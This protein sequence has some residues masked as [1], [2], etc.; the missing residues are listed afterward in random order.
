M[1]QKR[2]GGIQGAIMSKLG[3]SNSSSKSSSSTEYLN[4]WESTSGMKVDAQ[5]MDGQGSVG[6]GSIGSKGSTTSGVKGS[7]TSG[8]KGSTT[9]GVSVSKLRQLQS[10]SSS[11]SST[12]GTD[13][14]S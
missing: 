8:V 5:S 12:T 2:K 4:L 13:I 6:T 10:S 14:A 3:H 11:S 1:S 7:A 9:S